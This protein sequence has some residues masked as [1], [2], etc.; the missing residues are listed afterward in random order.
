LKTPNNRINLLCGSVRLGKTYVSLLKFALSA[1][2]APAGHEFIMVGKSVTA[3]KRNCL[4]LL[5]KLVGQSNF[6][7][8][9]SAKQA[10]LFGKTVWLEGANDARSESKIRGMTLGGAYCDEL[11][12]FPQDFYNMLL[13]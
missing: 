2:A 4:I 13:S 7:F 10:Q 3:L 1:A 5:E 11:T 6:R 12:M 8:S 9:V